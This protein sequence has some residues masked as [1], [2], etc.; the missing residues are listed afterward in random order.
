MIDG[1]NEIIEG[2]QDPDRVWMSM[3]TGSI[4]K[5]SVEQIRHIYPELSEMNKWDSLQRSI[6]HFTE[7]A[8]CR[9][10]SIQTGIEFREQAIKLSNQYLNKAI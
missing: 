4:A 6:Q 2:L 9:S 7:A 5:P 3:L 1:A 10:A 8:N